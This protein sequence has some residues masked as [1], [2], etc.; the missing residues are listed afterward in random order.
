MAK[1]KNWFFG[2]LVVLGLAAF[3]RFFNLNALPIFA[4]E[5]IYVRW[6]QVMRAESTLRFLP[7]SDGKQ[8]FF[9]WLTIPFFKI[10]SDPLVAGRV[11]SGLADL[12]TLAGVFF[13]SL[14][15]FSNK[16]LAFV[17][18]V[19]F[20]VLPYPVFFARLALADSLLAMFILW[21]FNLF[22]LAIKHTRLDFAMLAGFTLG[23][24]WL[25]KSPAEI[26]L[27]LLPTLVIFLQKFTRRSVFTALG[28]CLVTW[29]ISFGMYN[30]LRLGPEYQMIAIRNADYVYPISEILRHPLDP[31]VPHLKDTL[32]Y[33][34]YLVTPLGLVFT[35]WGLF[36]EKTS[37]WK[38]RLILAAWWI[39]PTM[40]ECAIAKVF[41]ARY[42][43]FT[44]P[45]AVLLIAHAV[46][47]IGQK[48]HPRYLTVAASLLVILPSLYTDHYLLTNPD[49][50][51]LPPN[52][53][54][55]YLEEWTA[56]TGLK[57]VSARLAEYAKTGPVLV[58]SEGFFGTPFSALQ[59]YL[60]STPNARIIGVGTYV[61]TVSDKLTNSLAD[62]QVFLVVNSTR[63]H[64]ADSAASGLQLLTSYPKSIRPDG[65][66]EFTLFFRVLPRK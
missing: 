39:L 16:R 59:V 26:A 41:T 60:N 13:A 55:G 14:V 28:L 15:L 64:I 25:T 33:Y 50:A 23:F 43:L 17:S 42:L 45:F 6:S 47:H 46:E 12:G 38:N 61:G 9:M 3:L 21:T 37:H 27:L 1:Y 31:L 34:L 58:G 52:E 53:R 29:V 48:I 4:D 66:R 19:I 11:V 65:T 18:A 62:N 2:G 24:A 51:P 54:S 20:A 5:S 57:D 35:F 56:G 49:L 10:I 36:A 44:V 30:I 8:P 22:A 63:F 7:L 40:A 32:S